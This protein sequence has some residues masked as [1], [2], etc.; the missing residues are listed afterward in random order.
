MLLKVFKVSLLAVGEY[1][2]VI[3]KWKKRFLSV[4]K[5]SEILEISIYITTENFFRYY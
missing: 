3:V 1:L 5:D 4:G 2:F